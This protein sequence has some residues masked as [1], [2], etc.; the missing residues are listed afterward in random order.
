MFEYLLR[1]EDIP[2][3][4]ILASDAAGAPWGL[5]AAVL[6]GELYYFDTMS[7]NVMN[8]GEQLIYFG[9]TTDDVINEVLGSLYYTSRETADDASNLRF[10]TCR[11]C[12]SWQI[13]D[14]S[15]LV[16]NGNNDVVEIEL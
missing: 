12:K 14:N 9:M 11:S 6:D 4:H 1:H 8:G 15:L 3:Y 10:D 7:E 13:S 2:A 5:S 16:T